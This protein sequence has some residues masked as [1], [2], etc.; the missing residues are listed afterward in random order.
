[1]TSISPLPSEHI[2][3]PVSPPVPRRVRVII[4]RR[5]IQNQNQPKYRSK[6]VETLCKWGR[7]FN[8]LSILMKILIVLIFCV[9]LG[10][11]GFALYL[12]IKITILVK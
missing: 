5:L 4:S 8:N 7:W 12:I 10:V 11:I 9:I 2:V 6:F 1:M 3:I